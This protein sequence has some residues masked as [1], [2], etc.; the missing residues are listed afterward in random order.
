M[1]KDENKNGP[2]DKLIKIFVLILIIAIIAVL[3]FKAVESFGSR[4]P[5]IEASSYAKD[6]YEL[7]DTYDISVGDVKDGYTNMGKYSGICYWYIKTNDSRNPL[8]YQGRCVG[9][10]MSDLD[11]QIYV[12]DNL[13]TSGND[14]RA[15]TWIFNLDEEDKLVP[16]NTNLE[17]VISSSPLS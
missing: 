4:S 13:Y 7:D 1:D 14:N 2:L 6:E 17:I 9:Y 8:V 5:K 15:Y 11:F 10:G 16:I 3:G 12:N